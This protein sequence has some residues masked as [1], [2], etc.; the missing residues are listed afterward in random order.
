[1]LK[2]EFAPPY[3]FRIACRDGSSKTVMGAVRSIQY[4][5]REAILATCMDITEHMQIKEKCKIIADY[6]AD[7][8]Y[9]L[10]LT[11]EHFTYVN[12]SVEHM[13]GYTVQEALHLQPKD[14]LTPESYELQ[15]R[16]MFQ[17]LENGIWRRTL[18]LDAVHKDGH[19]IPVEIHANFISNETSQPTEIVGIVHDIT[20]RKYAEEELRIKDAAL[21]S[22]VNAVAM[23]DME[24]NLIYVNNVM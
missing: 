17:D 3:Q 19:I 8:I 12:P 21:A 14:I 23:A 20:E 6:S 18:Q 16:Q 11:D 24:G 5:G 2:E 4:H 15:K 10:R 7:I 1:M 9:T 13:L 22:S